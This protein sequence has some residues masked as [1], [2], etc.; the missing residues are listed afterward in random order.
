MKQAFRWYRG[1]IIIGLILV[2]Q[3]FTSC[4]YFS[5]KGIQTLS[6]P[7]SS[8]LLEAPKLTILQN[9]FKPA[10][11]TT[12]R[13]LIDTIH[14]YALEGFLHALSDYN[15]IHFEV[16]SLT[17]VRVNKKNKITYFDW[18]KLANLS[19]ERGAGLF[20]LLYDSDISVRSDF[21][22]DEYGDV[23]ARRD[24]LIAN[25]WLFIDPEK[26]LVLKEDILIDTLSY[27]A[28]N[29]FPEA[30]LGDLPQVS[31]VLAELSWE[32]GRLFSKK[33][34]PIWQ[35]QQRPYFLLQRPGYD[36]GIEALKKNQLDKAAAVFRLYSDHKNKRIAALSRFNMALV[37]EI[38]GEYEIALDWLRESYE[39]KKYQ[40][41]EEYIQIMKRRI[42][43][44]KRLSP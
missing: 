6:P 16:D 23:E 12:K 14:R 33:Y 11:D 20:V 39:I 15:G 17:S 25:R 31:D 37:C 29:T 42:A 40:M 27:R 13:V 8:L 7:P 22:Y 35:D 30:A 1:L 38:R 28:Y 44:K 19:Q 21:F 36:R 24:F 5:Y 26:Q 9:S 43:E 10:G 41:T 4:T 2:V 34:I 18:Q 32:T 3:I